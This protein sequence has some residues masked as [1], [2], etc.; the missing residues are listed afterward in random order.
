MSQGVANDRLT[1]QAPIEFDC[2]RPPWVVLCTNAMW[3][4]YYYVV[5]EVGVSE[6]GGVTR[7][8]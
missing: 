6:Y 8:M 1:Y 7:G 3:K 4:Y 2:L 5:V